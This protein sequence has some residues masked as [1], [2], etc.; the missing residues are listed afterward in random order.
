MGTQSPPQKGGR[1]PSPIFGPFL[2]WPNGWMDQNGT[3]HGGRPQP[4]RLCIRW[5]PSPLPKK[6]AEPSPIFG[7]FL[8]CPNGWM[9]HDAT[10]YGGRTQPKGLCV[11]WDPA[12]LPKRGRSLLANFRPMSIAAKRLIRMALGMEV[13]LG[14]GHI[15]PDGKPAPLPQKGNRA[16][17]TF[18]PFLLSPN[19][20]MD[21][22]GTW[23]RGRPQPRRHCV[24]WGPS[25]SPKRGRSPLSNFR[26]MS[27]VAKRLDVSRWH[28]AM[29]RRWALIQATLC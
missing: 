12:T 28:L 11:R 29:A 24:Q 17:P 22:D 13:G 16:A 8:L 6:G 9:H 3:W 25:P 14:P 27:I 10:W 7:K 21:Q 26:P 20:W 1:A 5:G 19:G 2:L 23:H 18:S 4:R 15:V